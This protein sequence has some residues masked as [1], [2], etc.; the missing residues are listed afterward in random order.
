MKKRNFVNDE[1]FQKLIEQNKIL[2]EEIYR[3]NKR[4]ANL[5]KIRGTR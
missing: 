2:S 5:L 3:L 1:S 4:G